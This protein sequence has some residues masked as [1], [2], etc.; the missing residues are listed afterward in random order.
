[1]NLFDY[2]RP[3][4]LGEALGAAAHPGA[5][6]LA[7]GTNLVDLM[8]A[9]VARPE[10]IVDISRLPG[11][12][13][14]ETLEDGAIRIGALV[15]NAALARH[16]AVKAA[17]PA[18]AE[19]VLAGASAQLRNKASVGG[20]LLQATRCA[21]FGDP[22]SA[23]NRRA[24]GSGC[25]AKG[26]DRRGHAVLGWSDACSA[27]N[28]SDLLVP[29][30]ALGAVVEIAGQ[31]GTREVPVAEFHTLPGADGDAGGPQLR[32]GEIVTAVRLPA[33]AARF[34]AASR[35]VKV[36]ERTSFAFALVS[37]AA[38][39]DIEDGTIRAARLAL[40][41]VA[42]RPWRAAE[43]EAALTGKAPDAAV[44]QA[45]AEAAMAHARPSDDDN[46]FK[47]A[48][49][50]RVAVRALTL[51]AKGTPERMPALPASVFAPTLSTPTPSAPSFQGTAR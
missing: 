20:N 38:A 24:P 35:Y 27:T 3:A 29:L 15:G 17:A 11:L 31:D 5:A 25:D 39:L 50:V 1:M 10:R 14:I 22:A 23:C 9:G 47:I 7:G 18:V 2:V 4:T 28:P 26:G 44:F 45:A 42:A 12:S 43:A 36:R 37:A 33:D 8:K 19:A 46:A 13:E 41:G 21:Y 30:A 51:A 6:V 16:P 49:A 32:R 48:L 40:G 34:A